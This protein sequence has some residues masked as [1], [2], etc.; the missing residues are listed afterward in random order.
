MEGIKKIS[1]KELEKS[2]N[3]NTRQYLVGDLKLPQELEHIHDENVEVGISDYKK[4]TADVP[5][6]H[7]IV[8]EYQMI[9]KGYSEIKN[10]KTNEIIELNEGDFY[11][12]KKD[13]PYAQKSSMGTKILFFKFPGI[14][15]KKVIDID[16]ETQ[17][18]LN[19]EI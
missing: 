2:L 3:K 8:T 1:N 19:E 10:L 18:W 16:K 14:N 9:L 5:H 13:T 7:S 12:V 11:V 6:I 15:D 4:F 17:S